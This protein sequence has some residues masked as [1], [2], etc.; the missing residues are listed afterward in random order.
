[1]GT[2]WD[3]VKL[4][5]EAGLEE[6]EAI[7]TVLDESMEGGHQGPCSACAH[8]VDVRWGLEVSEVENW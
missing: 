5:A 7:H 6:D 3:V 2:T 8:D 4:A 1:V